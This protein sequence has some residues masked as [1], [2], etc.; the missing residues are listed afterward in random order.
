MIFEMKV[1]QQVQVTGP[2]LVVTDDD[3]YLV[4]TDG[5]HKLSLISIGNL[6]KFGYEF[7]EFDQLENHITEVWEERI[8]KFVPTDKL[9]LSEVTK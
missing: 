6:H 8:L 1:E 4:V 5:H 3:K 7:T 2:G 9:Q